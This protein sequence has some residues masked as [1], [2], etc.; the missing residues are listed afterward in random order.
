MSRSIAITGASSAIG[1]AISERL[2]QTGDSAVLHCCR[3]PE[4]LGEESA[5]IGDGC[6][7]IQ[8][9][10]TK[11]DEVDAFIESLPDLDVLVN[12][13][14]LTR[15]GLLA[16]MP[17]EDLIDMFHV[18][19]LALMRICR[20][21]IPAMLARRR[22]VIINVSSVTASRGN[23]GQSAYAGTKGFIESF[24]R[25]LAAEC[26]AKDVRINCVSPGPI[27]RGAI[28]ELLAH[29]GEEVRNATAMRRL[30]EPEDVAGLVA[31]LCSDDAGFITGKCIG[32]DGG[33]TQGV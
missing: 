8:A 10:F 13:A 31:Y 7:V 21:V 1:C 26:G 28:S 14:G 18:N 6:R 16:M 23:R 2:V 33:F 4:T 5:R 19:N 27:A 22:G 25:S 3:R 11:P 30:G 20:S 32:I 17:D 15:T 9:D 12:C 29:A 24:T